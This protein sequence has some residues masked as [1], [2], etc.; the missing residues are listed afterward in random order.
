MNINRKFP[1]KYPLELPYGCV[2]Y[3]DF[4]DSGNIMDKSGKGYHAEANTGSIAVN[5][6]N[7]YARYYDA[8]DDKTRIPDEI[9]AHNMGG[10]WSIEC[11]IKPYNEATN[12][13]IIAQYTSATTRYIALFVRTPANGNKLRLMLTPDGATQTTTDS[14]TGLTLDAWNYV[15]V[16]YQRV[17]AG[18]CVVNMYLNGALDK[19]ATNQALFSNTSTEVLEIGNNATSVGAGQ[20]QLK[21]LGIYNRLFDSAEAMDR[22]N[23]VCWQVGLAGK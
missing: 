14:T 3:Y 8:T 6:P 17:S 15:L 10:N 23:E 2:F 11:L 22:Y 7:G 21:L 18:A 19:T 20:M 9:L 5:A 13:C 16:T 1:D 4:E 12:K